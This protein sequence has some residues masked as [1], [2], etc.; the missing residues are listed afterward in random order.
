M[1][2]KSQLSAQNSTLYGLNTKLIMGERHLEAVSRVI[3][4]GHTGHHDLSVIQPQPNLSSSSK[5]VASIW[6]ADE[7]HNSLGHPW[8]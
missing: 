1:P 8:Q 4:T 7:I 5:N 2:T 3:V 6:L